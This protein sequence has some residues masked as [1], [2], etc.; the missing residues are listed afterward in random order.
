MK[1]LIIGHSV[2]DIIISENRQ[3][4]KPGG[5]AYSVA[6]LK[7][8]LENEDEIYLCSALDDKFRYLFDSLYKG[9]NDNYIQKI[10]SICVVELKIPDSGEREEMYSN[11]PGNL[12]L[13]NIDFNFFD[14]VYINMVSG[15][16]ISL[17]QLAE[18]RN[19]FGGLIYFDVHTFSR[20]VNNNLN[21]EFRKIPGFKNWAECIDIL[22]ANELEFRTLSDK[23]TENEITQELIEYGISQLVI[24]RGDKGAT[25]YYKDL[26]GIKS[27]SVNAIN[28]NSLNKVGCGDVFGALY[29]Y[30]Y[31]STK[32]ISSA[33]KFANTAAGITTAY[34][35]IKDYMNLKNDVQLRLNK[36]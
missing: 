14:G 22:Q 29:F 19:S 1:L 30:N 20:G 11:I 27:V 10:D 25:A 17:L 21:R 24:T 7:S 4:I 13:Q 5:I 6:G 34:G 2:A 3:V 15:F 32:N 12:S 8:F 18:I 33:L 28:I 16:D 26:S 35:D 36:K 9:I 31:I 23:L